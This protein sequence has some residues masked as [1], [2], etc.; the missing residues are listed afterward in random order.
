MSNND[1][2]Q[3]CRDSVTHPDGTK[4]NKYARI[5]VKHR[6]LFGITVKEFT[7]WL[8]EEL[9]GTRTEESTRAEIREILSHKNDSKTAEERRDID[10][11][12]GKLLT[13]MEFKQLI[14]GIVE[15]C[16]GIVMTDES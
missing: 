14:D 16:T 1:L 6:E 8:Y 7:G 15:D 13:Y 4:E 10:R 5:F 3:V 12:V 9:N 2:S 11:K